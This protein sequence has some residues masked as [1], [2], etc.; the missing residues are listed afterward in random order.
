MTTAEL[1]QHLP[2]LLLTAACAALL[3]WWL[4]GKKKVT[5]VASASP[6]K[7]AAVSSNSERQ[8]L[9]DLDAKLRATE[10]SLS[11]TQTELANLRK[12]SVSRSEHTAVLADLDTA[13]S[14]LIA[15]EGQLKK[16]REVQATLQGQT[17]DAGKKTQ[18]RAIALENELSSARTEII[19]L[20]TLADPNTDGMKRLEGEIET[21]RTRLR[22]VE[23]Q[24]SERNA[25]LNALK[26]KALSS[27]S[28]APRTIATVS[29][30][31]G[32]ALNLLGI[33]TTPDLTTS[34]S[35]A[36]VSTAAVETS[37]SSPTITFQQPAASAPES[38]APNFS[39]ARAILGKSIEADDLTL[40]EGI[41]PDIAQL[42]QNAGINSWESLANTSA[43]QLETLLA[44]AGPTYAVLQP[45]SWPE[46][47]RLA[48]AANWFQMKSLQ[49]KLLSGRPETAY[50]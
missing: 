14:S 15:L 17:N 38:S 43:E 2:V 32:A 29:A 36:L 39:S 45:G 44:N 47:A 26:A 5:P 41:S 48:T 34:S 37:D 11:S 33:E 8:R 50:V 21:V 10:A 42:L 4:R 1:T 25:E 27:T 7:T 6:A 28:R 9:K 23:A 31:P 13:R 16:S 24:L 22:A 20:K 19:R 46:Q 30:P 49:E 18:A 35:P 40:V 12:E 3:G